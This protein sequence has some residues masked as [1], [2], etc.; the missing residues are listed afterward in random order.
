MLGL[1]HGDDEIGL[2]QIGNTQSSGNAPCE[3]A[4]DGVLAEAL[5]GVG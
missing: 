4:G 3:A 2:G 1:E 5:A